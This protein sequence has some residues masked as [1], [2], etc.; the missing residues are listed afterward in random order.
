MS[1]VKTLDVTTGAEFL[2]SNSSV[3]STVVQ[4]SSII[5]VTF[6][7]PNSNPE[8]SITTVQMESWITESPFRPTSERLIKPIP[9]SDK[10]IETLITSVSI[11]SIVISR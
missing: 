6:L 11:S 1:G 8:C 2:I 4:T 3:D 7:I 10:S 9:N 5:T